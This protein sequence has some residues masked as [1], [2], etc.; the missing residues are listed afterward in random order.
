MTG[1]LCCLTSNVTG[2]VVLRVPV[3]TARRFRARNRRT[4][5]P[6]SCAMKITFTF[7]P[8]AVSPRVAALAHA[9]HTS[10]LSL[11]ARAGAHAFVVLRP[12]RF[13]FV[14]GDMLTFEQIFWFG[15]GG[16]C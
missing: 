13:C 2:R 4:R 9:R 14:R 1:V 7:D 11:S 3:S 16:S 6:T 12:G 5:R 15:D 8:L 10:D